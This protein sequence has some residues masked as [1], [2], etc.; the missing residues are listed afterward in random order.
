[1]QEFSDF[2]H[3]GVAMNDETQKISTA[4]QEPRA[5][6]AGLRR[7][8]LLYFDCATFAVI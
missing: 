8:S 7:T 3:A 5:S 1:L 2:R 6:A 4:E